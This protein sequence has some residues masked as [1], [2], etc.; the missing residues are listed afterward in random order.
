MAATREQLGA[1]AGR[2]HPLLFGTILF[3][4]SELMLF[5]GL[6][7]AYFTLR[8]MAAAWP[9]PGIRLEALEPALATAVLVSSS[10]TIQAGVRA[11][12][13]GDAVRFR[14]SVALTLL[15][16]TAFLG[17]QVRGW[18]TDGFGIASGAY[19]TLFYAMTGFHGLHVL[20]GLVLMLVLL[21]RWSLAPPPASEAAEAVAYYWHFV[22][23]VWLGL[24]TTL[25]VIR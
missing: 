7:A 24:F 20:A 13:R 16:G 5:G 11:L 4:A 19:G 10:L 21:A 12:L 3:L 2:P 18:L 14:R 6:F 9:P 23:V 1:T 22:D 25:Y 17:S 15:L 8:A